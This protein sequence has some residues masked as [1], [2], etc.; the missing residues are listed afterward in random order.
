MAGEFDFGAC[1]KFVEQC[2][3]DLVPPVCNDVLDF[4]TLDVA[5]MVRIAILAAWFRGPSRD[6]PDILDFISRGH[7]HA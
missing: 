2:R 1:R 6:Q 3:P 4:V 7:I 5:E